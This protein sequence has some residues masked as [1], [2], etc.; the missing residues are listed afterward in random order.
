MKELFVFVKIQEVYYTDKKYLLGDDAI[1]ARHRGGP[2]RWQRS[3]KPGTR[4]L[5][6]KELDCKNVHVGLK[7]TFKMKMPCRIGG[8]SGGVGIGL[9]FLPD[10]GSNRSW[11]CSRC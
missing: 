2:Q 11:F 9:K 1:T 6:S 3:E 4:I 10:L 7:I 5:S 8:V